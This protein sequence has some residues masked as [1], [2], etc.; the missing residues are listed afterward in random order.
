KEKAIVPTKE[1][2]EAL[3]PLSAGAE[4][5]LVTTQA[6]FT[7]LKRMVEFVQKADHYHDVVPA[8]LEVR[9]RVPEC[10]FGHPHCD[11]ESAASLSER[12][13]VA[14]QYFNRDIDEEYSLRTKITALYDRINWT[15]LTKSDSSNILIRNISKD[16]SEDFSLSDRLLVRPNYA[17]NTYM[18]AAGSSQHRFP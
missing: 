3:L 7:G 5:G 15:L 10:A 4:R 11:V 14:R 8:Y 18:L 6:R 17:M 13:L 16:M 12:L 1:T 9:K 2:R